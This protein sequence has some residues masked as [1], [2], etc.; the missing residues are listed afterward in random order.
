[1]ANK[2][3]GEK[4]V[5]SEGLDDL[6]KSTASQN[7]TM[8]T[9][10]EVCRPSMYLEVDNEFADHLINRARPQRNQGDT[11]IQAGRMEAIGVLQSLRVVRAGAHSKR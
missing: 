1:M 3:R 5:G 4:L 6:N 7:Q 2:S 8:S 9:S 10:S 11:P